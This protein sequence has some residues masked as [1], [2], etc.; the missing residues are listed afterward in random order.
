MQTCPVAGDP[1]VF[2]RV[3]V[4]EGQASARA[5]RCDRAEGRTA[6]GRSQA[7]SPPAATAG[8]HGPAAPSQP[9]RCRRSPPSRSPEAPRLLE[10]EVE[11]SPRWSRARGGRAGGKVQRRRSSRSWPGSP[12]A[13]RGEW[14]PLLG[15]QGVARRAG[16]SVRL[17]HASQPATS[18]QLWR[19]GRMVR[20]PASRRPAFGAVGN[21]SG[22]R[23]GSGLRAQ[24]LLGPG[25]RG[26]FRGTWRRLPADAAPGSVGLH[27]PF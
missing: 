7:R 25:G 5:P 17:A 8:D 4:K 26:A 13:P 24:G 11:P 16:A 27:Q 22:W 14:G 18:G 1:L 6:E 10:R 20:R 3:P 21:C 23:L 15:R 2:G 19:P 12:G 9:A